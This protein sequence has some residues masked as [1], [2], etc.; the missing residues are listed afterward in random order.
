MSDLGTDILE[1]D[2]L[3]RWPDVLETLL[4]DQ[5]SQ[6]NI[7]W[8]T[9]TYVSRYGEAYSFDNEILVEQIT[10]DHGDV[11]KPRSVKSKEEQEFRVRDRAEVFTPSWICNAQN[12]L[13]DSQ[14]FGAA[15]PFN[16]ETEKGWKANTAPIPFPTPTGKT[17]QD[18]VADTRLEISCGEAPYLAS[19]YDTITG[20]IIPVFERIGLLDRKLR[21]VSENTETVDEWEKSAKKAYQST[22]GY[23]WQGDNL[24]LARENL[25][26]TYVDFFTAKFGKEPTK[27]AI[28]EIAT[29]LS[30]NLWQMDGLKGVI[31]NTCHDTVEE[32]PSLFGDSDKVVTRCKGCE[33]DDIHKHNGIRCMIK[34]WSARKTLQ[35]V[36]LLK[37]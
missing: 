18:Y 28:R 25:L 27:K 14:W 21:V 3:N 33:K 12:N 37:Q 19:R 5:S 1:N 23:E 31:P 26:Y 10:G 2:I 20:D 17:W 30:W 13:V 34:D 29:I 9:D 22:Y 16:S 8:A 6:R 36:D 7:I 32:I 11:I 4:A 35:F 15:S 24:L